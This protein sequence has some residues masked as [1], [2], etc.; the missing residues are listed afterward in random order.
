[1]AAQIII[2]N[3]EIAFQSEEKA[4][5]AVELIIANKRLIIANN[6]LIIAN[7]ELIIDIKAQR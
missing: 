2:F 6:E 7:K 5:R 1:M 3:K 4:D